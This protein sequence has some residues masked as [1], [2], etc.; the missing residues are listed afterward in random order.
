VLR[1]M[2]QEQDE[3]EGRT[4]VRHEQDADNSTWS[5]GRNVSVRTA[6]GRKSGVPES[7]APGDGVG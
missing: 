7:P 2:V 3:S 5:R 6:Q 4:I 1:V